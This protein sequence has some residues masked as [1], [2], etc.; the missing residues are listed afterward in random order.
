MRLTVRLS[1]EIYGPV[2]YGMYVCTRKIP[3]SQHM[4]Q[5]ANG[6]IYGQKFTGKVRWGIL[7]ARNIFH[8]SELNSKA[9]LTDRCLFPKITCVYKMSEYPKRTGSELT[10]AEKDKNA[11][12]A[13]TGNTV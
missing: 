7:A 10:Q 13:D 3:F 1:I 9:S 2:A 4:L 12:L 6:K 8:C 11:L 5:L